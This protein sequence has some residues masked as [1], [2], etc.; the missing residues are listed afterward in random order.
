MKG[1]LYPKIFENLLDETVSITSDT[2]KAALMSTAFSFDESHEDWVDTHEITDSDYSTGGQTLPL[3]AAQIDVTGRVITVST[4][5]V[6]TFTS[7]GSIAAAY[8]VLYVSTGTPKL[9]ACFDF[10]GKEA[11]VNAEFKINWGLDGGSAGQLFK[12]T[13][14]SMA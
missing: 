3:T 9:L 8:A 13:T 6:T 2:V 4:T 12:I 14:A 7:T 10:E 5:G 1:A 11:S